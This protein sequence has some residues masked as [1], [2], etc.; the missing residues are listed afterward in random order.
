M[1][2]FISISVHFTQAEGLSLKQQLEEGTSLRDIVCNEGLELIFK[3][4]DFS[5]ACVNPS[6]AIELLERKWNIFD[7]NL[8]DV[9]TDKSEYQVGEKVKITIK[10]LGT[11]S[12]FFGSSAF[13]VTI[14][15]PFDKIVTTCAGFAPAEMELLPD[16]AIIRTWRTDAECMGEIISNG[17]YNIFV[18]YNVHPKLE[19]PLIETEKQMVTIT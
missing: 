14:L 11:K 4:T 15:D 16:E 9:S 3:S 10:N 18:I 19:L 6:T 7:K 2:F 5:P 13:G 12:A 17:E 8:V 1:V